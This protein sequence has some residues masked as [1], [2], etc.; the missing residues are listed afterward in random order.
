LLGAG[1]YP[2]N[3]GSDI[4]FHNDTIGD[5]VLG[6]TGGDGKTAR[7]ARP[8]RFIH[9]L[10]HRPLTAADLAL[11]KNLGAGSQRDWALLNLPGPCRRGKNT[12]RRLC[13]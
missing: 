10:Q 6:S 12:A 5:M 2:G 7:L 9:G 1:D 8:R 4:L 11:Q 13:P 3:G